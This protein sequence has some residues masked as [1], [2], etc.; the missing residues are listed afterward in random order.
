MKRANRASIA[1]CS[2]FF[3]ILPMRGANPAVEIATRTG[4]A[5]AIAAI[6][7]KP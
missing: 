6:A 3:K 4:P 1:A 7:T 2:A 5:L